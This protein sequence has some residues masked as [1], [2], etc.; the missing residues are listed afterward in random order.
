MKTKTKTTPPTAPTLRYFCIMPNAWAKADTAWRA[1]LNAKRE[2]GYTGR[3]P[4]YCVVFSYPKEEDETVYITDFGEVYGKGLV[5]I[6]DRR[7]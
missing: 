2:Y 1:I 4:K 7:N 6:M 3:K 5:K